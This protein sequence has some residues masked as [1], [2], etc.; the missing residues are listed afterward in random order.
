MAW[1]KIVSMGGKYRVTAIITSF[2]ANHG[3]K[4]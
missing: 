4:T 3:N 2:I 1:N